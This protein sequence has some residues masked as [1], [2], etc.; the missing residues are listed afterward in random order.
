MIDAMRE[1][2]E[3]FLGDESYE[4]IKAKRA[5]ARS[6]ANTLRMQ[7]DES[8]IDLNKAKGNK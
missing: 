1:R 4:I 2:A 7:I 3:A 8:E 6:R 5:E